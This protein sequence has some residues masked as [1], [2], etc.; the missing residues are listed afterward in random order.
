MLRKNRYA[1]EKPPMDSHFRYTKNNIQPLPLFYS[2]FIVN[3]SIMFQN[4]VKTAFF[5]WC[6]N[7]ET[8]E[9]IG[10]A[11]LMSWMIYVRFNPAM[12]LTLHRS[13]SGR[14]IAG[15]AMHFLPKVINATQRLRRAIACHQ[16]N[17][18]ADM[19]ADHD[20][21]LLPADILARNATFDQRRIVR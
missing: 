14:R 5:L 15:Q 16:I 2:G 18:L 4:F 7:T 13:L 1:K 10:G 20:L 9:G 3:T 17:R 19:I 11:D 21:N 12:S 6:Q 8:D